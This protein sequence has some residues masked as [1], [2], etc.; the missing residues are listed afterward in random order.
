VVHLRI[1]APDWLADRTL[2]LL[3]G[4]DSPYNVI[5][6]PGAARKPEGDVILCDLAREDASVIIDD[7]RE[8][9][10]PHH[11]SIAV[12]FI[13]TE[14]SEVA[15]EA[16]KAAAGLPGDAVIW[17]EVE[18]RTSENTELSFSFVA[19]MVLAV[20]IAAVGILLDQVILIIGAMV[21]G[22]E[23]GPLAG[24][25][26]AIV[27]KRRE[28]VRRSLTALAVGF[29]VAIVIGYLVTLLFK[30]L[31]LNPDDFSPEDLVFT[32][33]I[34]QP[35]FFSFWVAY[36]AGTVG[37]LSLTS[38]KSGALIGV[39]IS[40]TTI[41]AAANIGVAGAYGD[42]EEAS[43]AARQLGLNLVSLTLAGVVT[44]Y[45]QRRF[46]VM[47]RVKHLGDPAREA[48]GLPVG[49]S[50]KDKRKRAKLER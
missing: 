23:F 16:E 49:R 1:V 42:W 7:L 44:L 19:F 26:V 14:I 29:P 47:R 9:E 41:P 37:I 10:I 35:D 17:E 15:E 6:L 28:L 36:L 24:L 40:V 2:D 33:F 39:L 12:E 8:L 31:D 48:A 4:V 34:S 46:Y 25:A 30:A 38:A 18:A 11:G 20:L 32:H 45:L 21:V 50:V 22:P 27:E 5:H 3:C 43:G 13:D